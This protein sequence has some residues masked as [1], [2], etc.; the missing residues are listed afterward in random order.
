[1]LLAHKL[2]WA[3]VHAL[4]SP[5]LGVV[6]GIPQ[7]GEPEPKRAIS[8]D[9][10]RGL[11]E[12]QLGRAGVGDHGADGAQSGLFGELLHELSPFLHPLQL[13][14]PLLQQG[15]RGGGRRGVTDGAVIGR[16]PPH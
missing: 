2:V 16:L 3:A 12:G 11:L 4:Q 10:S 7:A 6:R 14:E 1:M 8:L 13:S 15:N 9:G 5:G